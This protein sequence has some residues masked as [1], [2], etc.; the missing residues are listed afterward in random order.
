MTADSLRIQYSIDTVHYLADTTGNNLL[1]EI[2]EHND[3]GKA[4][5]VTGHSNTLSFIIEKLGVAKQ[6]IPV[7]EDNEFDYLF[8]VKLI[9]EKSTLTIKKYGLKQVKTTDGKTMQ[10]LQ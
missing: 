5:L 3:F 7:I 2:K 10:P 6:A 9:K 4:I 1:E 8:V